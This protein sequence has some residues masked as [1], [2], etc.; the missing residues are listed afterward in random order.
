MFLEMALPDKIMMED[1]PYVSMSTAKNTVISP[2]FLVSKFCREAQFLHRVY[3]AV[4]WSVN[5]ILQ[6]KCFPSKIMQKRRQ[7]E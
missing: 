4:I 1:T 3:Y 2:N 6:E 5:R 7:G